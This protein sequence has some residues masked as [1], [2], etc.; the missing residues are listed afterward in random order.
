MKEKEIEK[1]VADCFIDEIAK[2]KDIMNLFL[3]F[4]RRNFTTRE[5]SDISGV[6][7][8]T[9]W[10][11]V[12]KIRETWIDKHRENWSLYILQSQRGNSLPQRS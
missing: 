6:P 5:L 11:F 1:I 4:P 9:A 2:H 12:K 7:Y 3:K 8:S 10:R